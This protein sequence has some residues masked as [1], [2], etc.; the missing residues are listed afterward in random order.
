MTTQSEAEG[1]APAVRPTHGADQALRLSI[2]GDAGRLDVAVPM[3]LDVAALAQEYADTLGLA[4]PPRLARAGGRELDPVAT[5]E[6]VLEQGDLLV[7]A[8]AAPATVSAASGSG[9]DDVAAPGSQRPAGR[10]AAALLVLAGVA[11]FAAAAVGAGLTFAA[12]APFWVRPVA[13]TVLLVGALLV[14]APRPGDDEAVD[15]GADLRTGTPRVRQDD[16][17]FLAGP[18]L[19]GA[20]GFVAAASPDAGGLLLALAVGGLAAL[21]VA[22]LARTGLE[23]ADEHLARLWLVT[24]GIVCVTAVV[25]L[26]LGASPLA[27]SAVGFGAA[28][29]AT[30]VLPAFA[31]DVDDDV[32]LDLD[33]LAVTAWSAREQPRSG[34]KRNQ[35][36]PRMVR[37][38]ARRSQRTVGT[39]VVVSAVAAAV[40]GPFVVLGLGGDPTSW[41]RWGGVALVLLGAASLALVSR[42]FRSLG[43]RTLL[44][45]T[46]AWL[47]A[48]TGTAVATDLGP[49]AL[50]YAFAAA[51]V[52][53]PAVLLAAVR[54]GGGWR[55]VWWARVGEI[56]ETLTGVFVLALVPLASGLFD[57]VRTSVG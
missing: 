35:V 21:V 14:A 39:G 49:D 38:V 17:S 54:L 45:L 42:S 19:A 33:R 57:L 31:V 7:A 12:D 27:L 55:S 5:L 26:L 28:V 23:G 53:A 47:V 24:G 43:L 16:W 34:R 8:D 37:E 3:W 1:E 51:L 52:V 56:L 30:R 44:G 20:A 48:L 18:G 4:S 6:D 9:S 15:A 2:L 25:W 11:G 10:T 36:R 22:A 40:T 46:A 32:L 29:V 41:A 50:W 13:A